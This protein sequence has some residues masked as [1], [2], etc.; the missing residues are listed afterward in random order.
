MKTEPP[1]DIHKHILKVIE[2]H[3]C[4]IT[5]S[6]L[7]KQLGSESSYSG[8]EIKSAIKCLIDDGS[9]MYTNFFGATYIEKSIKTP[10][11]LS[12][13][14]IVK[15]PEIVIESHKDDV[16]INI[17]PGSAFGTGIPFHR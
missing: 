8:E 2:T 17:M 10:L 5:P 4:K 13:H 6:A 1:F 11:R 12:K 9:L 15:P 14:V 16:V 3:S 7:K